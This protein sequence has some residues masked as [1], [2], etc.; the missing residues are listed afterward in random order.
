MARKV[1]ISVVRSFTDIQR[2][3]ISP[4]T[5]MI[6]RTIVSVHDKAPIKATTHFKNDVAHRPKQSV[7]WSRELVRSRLSAFAPQ[8]THW[9]D[10]SGDPKDP[11]F[12]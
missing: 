4:I 5:M 12:Q 10:D 11:P 8:T 9:G 2:A 1:P 3:L 7:D 6:E